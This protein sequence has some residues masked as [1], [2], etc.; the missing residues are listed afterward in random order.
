MSDLMT[1]R[2]VCAWL[3]CDIR[4]LYRYIKL[5]DL[6]AH[7]LAKH[8]RFI[9]EDIEEWMNSRGETGNGHT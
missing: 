4:T 6:P 2:E 5:Y 8:Y 3:K 7:R 1:S 9:R